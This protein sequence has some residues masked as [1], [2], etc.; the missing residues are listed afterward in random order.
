VIVFIKRRLL[1]P[2]TRWLFEYTLENFRRQHRTNLALMACL[3]TLAVEN[4]KLRRELEARE[5]GAAS[6]GTA[7]ASSASGASS[8]SGAAAS[9]HSRT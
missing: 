5:P 8:T 9:H 7:S 1:L 4:V 2:L 3:Q 6:S